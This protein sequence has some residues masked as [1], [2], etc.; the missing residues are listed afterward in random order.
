MTKPKIIRQEHELTDPTPMVSRT[1]FTRPLSAHE[2]V[3][4]AFKQHDALKSLEAAPGDDT[5]DGPDYE[6]QTPHQLTE[7]PV[8][9]Q[10]MTAG[11]LHMLETERA[12]AAKEVQEAKRKAVARARTKPVKDVTPKVTTEEPEESDQDE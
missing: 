11:E 6:G 7:D 12:I 5:F 1:K 3:L 9:G 8:T 2:R 10:E 4:R